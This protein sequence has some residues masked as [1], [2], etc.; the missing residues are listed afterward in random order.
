VLTLYSPFL[1][2]MRIALGT[3]DILSRV[4]RPSQA[5]HQSVSL[6]ME[7]SHMFTKGQCY[8]VVYLL[9]EINS[10]ATTAYAMQM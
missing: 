10:I 3:L 1:T 9:T 6:T 8:I 5:V 4:Y 7:V 2:E